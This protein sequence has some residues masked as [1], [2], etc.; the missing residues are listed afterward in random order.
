MLLYQIY[1]QNFLKCRLIN[2][3][4][5][6]LGSV[7]KKILEKT[8]SA[9]KLETGDNLWKSTTDVLTW[10]KD[11]KDLQNAR[12]LKFDIQEFYPSITAELLDRALFVYLYNVPIY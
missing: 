5:S 3:A 6:N 9:T 4:K 10:F 1:Q 11:L 8:I 7:S 12:F 2:P